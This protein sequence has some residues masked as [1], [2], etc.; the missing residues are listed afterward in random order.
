MVSVEVVECPQSPVV[1]GVFPEK[2]HRCL[3][4]SVPMNYSN[5]SE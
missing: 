1:T 2:L 4:V 5:L 3:I